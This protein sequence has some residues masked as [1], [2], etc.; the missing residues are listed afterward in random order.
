MR[1]LRLSSAPSARVSW[2]W[3]GRIPAGR[4]TL[5]DAMPGTG[6]TTTA[7]H[8]IAIAT[9]GLPWP[10]GKKKAKPT[11]VIYLGHEDDPGTLRA[12]VEAAGGDTKRVHL[13]ETNEVGLFPLLPRD[14]EELRAL[15][16]KHE[17][18]VLVLDPLASYLDTGG[19]DSKTRAALLPLIRLAAEVG[20]TVIALRHPTKAGASGS[21]P[22]LYRAGGGSVAI[23]ALARAAYLLA[24]DPADDG[25]LILAATKASLAVLPGS[26]SLRVESAPNGAPRVS[27]LGP[28]SV[29]AEDLLSGSN[30]DRSALDDARRWLRGLLAGGRSVAASEIRRLAA[31]DGI[32][33]R[34][35]ERA[36]SSEKVVAKRTAQ[37]WS[38]VML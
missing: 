10:D 26:L 17:A 16:V 8:L 18:T 21:G 22:A 37:G 7:A 20:L 38:W 6:K 30:G 9:A 25:R 34:T 24:R 14:I 31:Q 32:A 1:T 28:S 4:L 33:W 13:W 5:L 11:S 23:P 29:S 27:W 15:V 36:K 3:P 19:G 2:L 12:R 35:V